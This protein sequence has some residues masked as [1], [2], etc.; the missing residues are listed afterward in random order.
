M[1][2]YFIRHAQSQN[3]ALYYESGSEKGRWPD[4]ELTPLGQQQA[5]VL[6]TF[7]A[8]K[9]PDAPLVYGYDPYNRKGFEFTHLYCSLMERAVQTGTAV[10]QALD[11]PLVAWPEWHERGGIYGTD[12]ESEERHGLPGKEP[13]YFQEHYPHLI[14]PESWT[15]GGWWQRRPY[16]EVPQANERAKNVVKTLWQRHGS[17]NDKVAIVSHAGFFSSVMIALMDTDFKNN[18]LAPA[19]DF[20]FRMSNVGITRVNLYEQHIQISYINRVDFLPTE[21]LT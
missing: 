13:S 12:P 17:S 6:A 10:S 4:P 11:L 20:W 5:A 7:L 18:L 8:K 2:L 16:E 3:N 1:E 19:R 14:L 21:I 15:E 9:E